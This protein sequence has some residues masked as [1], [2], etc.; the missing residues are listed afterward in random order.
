M[1]RRSVWRQETLREVSSQPQ[2]GGQNERMGSTSRIREISWTGFI[3]RWSKEMP[4]QLLWFHDKSH[5]H[6]PMQ[7]IYHSIHFSEG[8]PHFSDSTSLDLTHQDE[9]QP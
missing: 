1:T 6:E 2:P 9:H 5:K 3:T 7:E 4:L 8:M